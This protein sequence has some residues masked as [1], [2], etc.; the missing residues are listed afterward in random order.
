MSGSPT[1]RFRPRLDDVCLAPQG[2][3]GVLLHKTPPEWR[4][5]TLIALVYI[6]QVARRPQS[7]NVL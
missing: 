7:G 3:V 2:E 5:D 1:S 4:I 6:P